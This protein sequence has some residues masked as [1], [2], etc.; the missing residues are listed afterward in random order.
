VKRL[1]EYGLN[2]EKMKEIEEEKLAEILKGV[3]F[4][5]TKA[6]YIK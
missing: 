2:V 6:K 5:I 3:S 1:Q 4:H